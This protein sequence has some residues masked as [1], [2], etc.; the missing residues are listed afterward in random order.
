MIE[1]KGIREGKIFPKQN[2]Y[3]KQLLIDNLFPQR[4]KNE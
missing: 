1:K 3:K 4:S 2:F